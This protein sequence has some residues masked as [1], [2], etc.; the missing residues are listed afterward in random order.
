M[1]KSILYQSNIF[2]VFFVSENIFNASELSWKFIRLHGR[3]IIWYC[4]FLY[5]LRKDFYCPLIFSFLKILH[6]GQW[7]KYIICPQII[8]LE[9][10][11]MLVSYRIFFHKCSKFLR[12][13]KIYFTAYSALISY[14]F[15]FPGP[16][17]KFI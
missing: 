14:F 4:Y 13:I 7:K 12:E 11:F 9:Y 6:H 17:F 3:K 16:F 8:V 1:Q 2:I 5:N 10:S 15:Y